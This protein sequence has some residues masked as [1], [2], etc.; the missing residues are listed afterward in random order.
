MHACTLSLLLLGSLLLSVPAV[1]HAQGVEEGGATSGTET[2]SDTAFVESE[3]RREPDASATTRAPALNQG[4]RGGR[5]LLLF[6]APGLLLASG[7]LAAFGA[8]AMNPCVIGGCDP[9]EDVATGLGIAS[10]AVFVAA[11]VLFGVGIDLVSRAPG[12]VQLV[13]GP[14][15]L[16]A[17]IT[18]SF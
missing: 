10:G 9:E 4:S 1:A 2:P 8:F 7:A 6:V 16:G 15:E 11:V 14:G 17:G 5:A 18:V 3:A 12:P 13:A